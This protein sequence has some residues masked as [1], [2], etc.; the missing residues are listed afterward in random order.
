[1]GLC[2]TTVIHTFLILAGLVAV[3]SAQPASD[4]IIENARIYTGNPKQPAASSLA[5]RHGRISA[6]GTSLAEHRGPRTRRLDLKGAV[7]IPGFIDA[8]AHMAG[9]GDLLRTLDFRHARSIA[10]VCERVREAARTRPPGQWIRGRAWDQTNWGGAFPAAEPL[11]EAAPHHP[12]FLTRVDGHAGWVNRKALELAGITKSTPDPPGGRII[13]DGQGSPTGILI[14]RAQ[15][16]V[17]SRIPAMPLE[18]IRQRI[19]LAARE[20]AR[21]GLTGVHDA[22]VGETELAAYRELISAGMLPVRVYAMIG[23]AGPHWRS[24]LAKGPEIGDRLTVRSI[25]LMADGAMGSRGA[26]VWQPYSDDPGNTGLLL[27]GQ[28]DIERIA[29]EAISRGFQVNTHAIGDRAN[30]IVLDAYGAVLK[31]ANSRRFRIEHA[32]VVSLPDF[33][34]FA[35][36]GVI[37][38]IQSTHATSDMRW[39]A[40]RLGPDRLAGAWAARRFLRAG[41]RIAN[42]SDFPVEHVNPLWGFYAAIAR[43]DHAG[44]P[45]DGFLPDQKLTREEALR[46]FTIDAA[47]AAFEENDKGTIEPGKFADFIVLSAD[48]MKIPPPEILKTRVTS[49]FLGGE[50]V[51]SE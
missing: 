19:E 13:R 50:I 27:L 51:Y 49:T 48:I 35:R 39:A 22:G 24:W 5:V 29:R 16:L 37:A 2:N 6:V 45:P 8:H 25:K 46:S 23:G 38:S 12:V 9:L 10:E 42:G 41:V 34:L 14:D 18:E 15:D 4:L 43:Q 11:T 28:A 36:Y 20:C 40:A 44:R 31:G 32:Q 7:V 47:Y 1:M 33:A 30:R 3:A 17:R 21:M 26:A